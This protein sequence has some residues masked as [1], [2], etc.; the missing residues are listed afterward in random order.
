MEA[1]TAENRAAPPIVEEYHSLKEVQTTEA[2]LINRT[3]R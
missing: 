3:L 2:R 1:T